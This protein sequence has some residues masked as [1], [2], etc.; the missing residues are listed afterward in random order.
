MYTVYDICR[1]AHLV[2]HQPNNINDIGDV[3]HTYMSIFIYINLM[4]QMIQT[5]IFSTDC[6][7]NGI[8]YIYNNYVQGVW[9]YI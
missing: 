7:I 2:Y 5:V 1:C 8:T 4:S 9:T 6:S 3:Y